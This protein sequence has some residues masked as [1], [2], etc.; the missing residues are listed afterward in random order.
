M[1][2]MMMR[3]ASH[4]LRGVAAATFLAAGVSFAFAEPPLVEA[5]YA[6]SEN[7]EHIDLALIGGARRTLDVAAYVLSDWV[8]IEALRAAE[9]RGV[10]VRIVLDT[11]Q[12]H[13]FDRLPRPR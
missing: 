5:H 4:F 13:A 8:V 2:S 6:P 1:A 10:T 12:R 3:T 11:G 7:L 9:A